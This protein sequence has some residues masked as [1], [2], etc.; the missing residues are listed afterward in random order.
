MNVKINISEKDFNKIKFK[1]H[2][3]QLRILRHNFSNYDQLISDDNWKQVTKSFYIQIVKNYPHLT[4]SVKQ[5]V[6]YKLS[7]HI[8]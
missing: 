7:N 5:W 6:T 4:N 8:R 2:H 1:K 3:D